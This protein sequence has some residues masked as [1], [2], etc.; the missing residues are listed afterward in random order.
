MLVDNGYEIINN[1]ISHDFSDYLNFQ[2]MNRFKKG[3]VE[4]HRN[5]KRTNHSYSLARKK[6]LDDLSLYATDRIKHQLGVS[7]LFPYYNYV[8]IYENGSF[9]EPHHD[10][11]YLQY[12][13]SINVCDMIYP[14]F[15]KNKLVWDELILKKGDAALLRGNKTLHKRNTLVCKEGEY[16]TSIVLFFTEKKLEKTEQ[17]GIEQ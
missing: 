2:V 5:D 4:S 12:S 17:F 11:H 13:L 3:E 10:A 6:F 1:F 14:L 7:D 8:R 15:V 9:L 16:M